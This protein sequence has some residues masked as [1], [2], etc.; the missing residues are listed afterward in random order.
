MT[1]LEKL[2]R[3]IDTILESNERDWNELA[4]KPFTKDERL[5]LR[6]GIA[7]R[8]VELADLLQRKWELEKR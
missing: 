1:E 8:E 5:G 2:Q 3:D 7:M 4:S 6:K